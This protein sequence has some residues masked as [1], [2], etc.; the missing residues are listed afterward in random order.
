MNDDI[1]QSVSQ[2]GRGE[3]IAENRRIYEVSDELRRCCQLYE[4]QFRDGK[5]HVSPLEVEQR[6]AE[7]YAKENGIWIPMHDV[8]DL[9]TPGPSGNENDTYVSNDLVY[10]VNN[11]LNSGS[12]L[13]LLEKIT[14]HNILF[15]D[16]FYTLYGFTGFD[17]RTIMPILQQRLVKGAT[18][19]TTIEI[20]TY[21]AALGFSKLNNEG[22]YANTDFE[23][24]D[25]VPR[26]VLKDS[27][28]DI[29]IIDAEIRL[30]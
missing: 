25:L 13:K 17:G 5:E 29:F 26:N 3:E 20:D 21:M 23:V 19:A 11:L 28:G 2:R 1:S 4:A 16:T 12:I 24:W 18:P 30:R 22:R 6:V 14:W 7:L 8:F 10:K 9:G 15:Y 27:S